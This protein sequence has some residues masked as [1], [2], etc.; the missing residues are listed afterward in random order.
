MLRVSS[1]SG[2]PRLSF[3]RENEGQR[4]IFGG[5]VFMGGHWKDLVRVTIRAGVGLAIVQWDSEMPGCWG[6]INNPCC[7]CSRNEISLAK[8]SPQLS[9]YLPWSLPLLSPLFLSPL[10][11]LRTESLVAGHFVSLGGGGS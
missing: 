11:R 5:S 8:S 4:S 2:A 1:V 9:S 3:I 7:F 6:T 10:S